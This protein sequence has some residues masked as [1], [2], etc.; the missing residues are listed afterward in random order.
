M[1]LTLDLRK[2]APS[3]FKLEP[4][5]IMLHLWTDLWGEKILLTH[6]DVV[7]DQPGQY[8]GPHPFFGVIS[9]K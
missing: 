4:P 1:Q 8:S 9:P 2:E 6:I 3:T 7:E 5:A